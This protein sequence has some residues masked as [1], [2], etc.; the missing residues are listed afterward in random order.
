MRSHTLYGIALIGVGALGCSDP[1]GIGDVVSTEGTGRH[2]TAEAEQVEY[3]IEQLGSLGGTASRGASRTSGGRVAGFSQLA[4]DDVVRATLWTGT[5]ALDLGT[6]GGPNSSVIWPGQNDRGMIVGIAQT[7][8]LDSL[9][10]RW[11]CASFFPAATGHAC[12]GFVWQN[13]AMRALPTLGGQNGFATGINNRGQAVGWAENTVSDPT[14][15]A[16][17]VRQFRAVRWGPG[18]DQVQE[19][20]PFADGTTSAATGINERGQV[21][22][23]SGICANAFGGASAR[24]AVLWDKDGQPRDLGD[25]GGSS[26]N[27]P[28]AINNGGDVVGFAN[29]PGENGGFTLHAVLWPRGQGIQP[30]GTLEGNAHSQAHSINGH[31]QIVGVSSGGTGPTRAFI[32]QDGLLTDLN[33]LA[34]GYDGV[35]VDARHINDEG[36]ITGWARDAT[37]GELVAFVARPIR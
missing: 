18:P 35:L 11:S 32:W 23:I 3:E 33:A 16:P 1:P 9:G 2:V 5:E 7:A 17:Q 14:C 24:H 15:T 26:W 22:G 19:L 30:L 29:L 36:E 10:Q 13:G 20:P 4:G 34:P 37:S 25:L 21:V 12:V 8:E 31:G 28:M 6:L 27:T